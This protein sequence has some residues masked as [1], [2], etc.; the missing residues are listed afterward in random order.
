M[1]LWCSQAPTGRPITAQAIG[2]GFNGSGGMPSPEEAGP[3]PQFIYGFPIGPHRQA[4]QRFWI[5][6]QGSVMKPSVKPRPLAWA[7]M[8]RP[9]WGSRAI[10]KRVA[11]ERR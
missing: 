7:M 9:F 11:T 4:K 10:A 3:L 6:P 8:K 1:L 5:A 2:L